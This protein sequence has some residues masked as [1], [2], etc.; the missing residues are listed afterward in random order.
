MLS[1]FALFNRTNVVIGPICIV[2]VV[3]MWCTFGEV[4]HF[5]SLKP[6]AFFFQLL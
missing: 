3:Y 5:A 6:T 4:C 2:H 1:G